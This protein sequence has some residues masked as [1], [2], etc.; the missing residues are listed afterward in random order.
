MQEEFLQ[1]VIL[2]S[3]SEQFYLNF[4]HD[5]WKFKSSFLVAPRVT[6]S[7]QTPIQDFSSVFTAEVNGKRGS[8][9]ESNSEQDVHLD[10]DFSHTNRMSPLQTNANSP[11]SSSPLFSPY[12]PPHFPSVE[13]NEHREED[14]SNEQ[15]NGT[16]EENAINPSE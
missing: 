5:P 10:S 4:R 1:N 12:L 16:A 9:D 15:A 8:L 13:S 7:I 2:S 3:Q 14:S 11:S 6:T